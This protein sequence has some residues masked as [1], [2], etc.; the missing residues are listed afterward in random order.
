MEI[1]LGFKPKRQKKVKEPEKFDV[2]YLEM[3][4]APDNLGQGYKFKLSSKAVEL[5][6]FS[7]GDTRYISPGWSSESGD[8]Y[9]VRC[10]SLSK[11]SNPLTKKDTFSNKSLHLALAKSK[12][13]DTNQYNYF[14]LKRV[15]EPNAPTVKIDT[16]LSY[17]DQMKDAVEEEHPF[18]SNIE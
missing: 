17:Y 1:N 16:V 11:H 7:H 4:P 13:V 14:E 10:K 15:V 2:P 6:E 3:F 9:L 5:L 18:N 12:E 8:I